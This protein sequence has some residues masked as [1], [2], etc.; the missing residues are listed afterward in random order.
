MKKP[1]KWSTVRVPMTEKLRLQK[2][3]RKK[4]DL[5]DRTISEC[6]LVTRAVA[7]LCTKEE[8]KLGIPKIE[9]Q[10]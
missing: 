3:V 7:T 1:T 2:I 9:M 4:S 8:R 5:E 10:L 6:E